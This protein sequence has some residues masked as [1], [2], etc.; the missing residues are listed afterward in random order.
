M[1]TNDN[2]RIKVPTTAA[3]Y[4]YIVILLR[5]NAHIHTFFRH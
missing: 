3:V 1:Y 5:S 2:I 4:L